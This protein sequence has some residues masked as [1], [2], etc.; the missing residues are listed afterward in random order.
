MSDTLSTLRT[1]QDRECTEVYLVS[2]ESRNTRLTFLT[3]QALQITTEIDIM[4][5]KFITF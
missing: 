2:L 4:K 3:R 5:D 1:A